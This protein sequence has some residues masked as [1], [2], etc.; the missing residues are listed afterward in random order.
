MSSRRLT[1]RSGRLKLPAEVLL[2]ILDMGSDQNDG[3]SV[4]GETVWQDNL[5]RKL[6]Q[7]TSISQK[8]VMYLYSVKQILSEKSFNVTLLNVRL[9]NVR[10]LN[11]TLLNVRTWR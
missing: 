9:L 7:T 1:S 11:V 6:S 8:N 2:E 3:T 4:R 5:L 10:L